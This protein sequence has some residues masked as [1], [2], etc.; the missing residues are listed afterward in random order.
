[1]NFV[2]T[3]DSLFDQSVND[4]RKN[5]FKQLKKSFLQSFKEYIDDLVLQGVVLHTPNQYDPSVR[6]Q[7]QLEHDEKD[8]Y[9]GMYIDE[10]LTPALVGSGLTS[11]RVVDEDYNVW[12]DPHYALSPHAILKR[13]ES[14]WT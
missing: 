12:T 4:G 9:K 11:R 14:P 3:F 10:G 1:M 7:L 6:L 8:F 5:A 2:G 13:L